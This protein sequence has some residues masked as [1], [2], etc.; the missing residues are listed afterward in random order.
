MEE[1]DVLDT[2]ISSITLESQSLNAALDW[3]EKK[4]LWFNLIVG[5]SGLIVIVIFYSSFQFVNLIGAVFYGVLM[6][7]MYSLGF[8]LEAL[9]LHY[10]KGKLNLFKFRNFFFI[11]GVILVGLFTLVS[12]IAFYTLS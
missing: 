9:D 10:L 4:R 12:G 11:S 8:F 7:I 2:E 1:G 3:W 6:N 5:I